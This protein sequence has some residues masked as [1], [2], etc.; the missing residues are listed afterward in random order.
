MM[1]APPITAGS[2]GGLAAVDS[3]AVK[4]APAAALL[5]LP[6]DAVDGGEIIIFAVKPSMLAPVFDSIV[7]LLAGVAMAVACLLGGWG[8]SHL[9]PTLTAQLILA[10]VAA[11]L[12]IAI[13][14][15]VSCWYVLTN[16]RVVEITGV[17][18]P[19][20]TSAMLVDIRN[21]YVASVLY[22]RPLK[23]GT[24]TFVSQRDSDRPWSWTHVREPEDIHRAIRKAIE[25]AIDSMPPR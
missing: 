4:R 16:R 18:S 24:I 12:L 14:R 25:N 13:I 17:R 21:T 20:V 2:R 5:D 1:L 11:R 6:L 3:D 22:E 19:Q 7:W 9:S 8:L 23:L 10:L 15:W